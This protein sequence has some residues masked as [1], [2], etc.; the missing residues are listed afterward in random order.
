MDT[1]VITGIG[2]AE[3]K[4]EAKVWAADGDVHQSWYYP[5]KG[6]ELDMVKRSDGKLVVGRVVI[7]N[8]CT[9]KT[10]RGIGIGS[11][12]EDVRIG[13]AKEIN[14]KFSN[15]KK[16]VVAGTVYGGVMFSLKDGVVAGIL[17]GD[18]AE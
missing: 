5:Q 11:S 15:G 17:I 10:K 8:P 12:E 6:I 7:T 13:Y 3:K 4:S 1:D 16:S 18:A 9:Y 14:P 2:D